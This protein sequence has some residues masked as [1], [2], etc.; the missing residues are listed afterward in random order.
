METLISDYQSRE[1]KPSTYILTSAM[2]SLEWN[3][4]KKCIVNRTQSL[5]TVV[6]SQIHHGKQIILGIK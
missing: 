3:K 5:N 1:A 4:L 6:V 2:T